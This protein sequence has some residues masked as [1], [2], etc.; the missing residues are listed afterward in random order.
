M[1]S[2]KNGKGIKGG[3]MISEIDDV[4]TLTF[5]RPAGDYPV[6]E[7]LSALDELYCFFDSKTVSAYEGTLVDAMMMYAKH[8]AEGE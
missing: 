2:L 4:C 8:M 7:F 3:A 5:E 1:L 6:P